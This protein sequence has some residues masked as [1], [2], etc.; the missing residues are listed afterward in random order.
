MPG[1]KMRAGSFA[2]AVA[3]TR[4]PCSFGAVVAGRASGKLSSSQAAST[5]ENEDPGQRRTQ[6]AAAVVLR[7]VSVRGLAPGGAVK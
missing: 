6:Q 7:K 3:T 1:G 5:V 2:V 4:T